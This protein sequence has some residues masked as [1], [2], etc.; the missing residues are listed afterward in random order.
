LFTSILTGIGMALLYPTLI[1]AVSDLSHP[2]QRAS[3]LG[4]YRMWRDS[5]YAIGAIIIGLFMDIYTLT[6]SFYLTSFLMFVSGLLIFII[7]E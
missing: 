2:T 7:M 6:M 3:S 4:V 5:G 1:A